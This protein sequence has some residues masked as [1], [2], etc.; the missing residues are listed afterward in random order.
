MVTP[1]SPS[2]SNRLLHSYARPDFGEKRPDLVHHLVWVVPGDHVAA[3][4]YGYHVRSRVDLFERGGVCRGDHRAL[5][6]EQQERRRLDLVPDRLEQLEMKPC[7]ALDHGGL[8]AGSEPLAAQS[9]LLL[10]PGRVVRWCFWA[11]AR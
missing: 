1:G 9:H 11:S 6:A 7:V 3:A 2:R 5:R 4:R 10:G 8:V